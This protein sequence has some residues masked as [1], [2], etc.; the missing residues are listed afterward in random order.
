[1]VAI[2]SGRPP[3]ELCNP[4]SNPNY[5]LKYLLNYLSTFYLLK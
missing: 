5:L 4:N 2:L 3:T 1:M